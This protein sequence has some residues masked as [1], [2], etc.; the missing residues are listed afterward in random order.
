MF[1][2][3]TPTLGN[4]IS[5]NYLQTYL[6]VASYNVMY[7]E[8]VHWYTSIVIGLYS[9]PMLQREQGVDALR[10]DQLNTKAGRQLFDKH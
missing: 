6:H 5:L 9:I 7:C 8:N 3:L 2:S 4:Q 1:T 10:P